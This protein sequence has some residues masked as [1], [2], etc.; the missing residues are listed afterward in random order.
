MDVGRHLVARLDPGFEIT[1]PETFEDHGT[2]G[3]DV[4]QTMVFPNVLVAGGPITTTATHD[5]QRLMRP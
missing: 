5:T 2:H 4:N 1:L 3:V